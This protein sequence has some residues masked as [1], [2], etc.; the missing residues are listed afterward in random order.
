MEDQEDHTAPLPTLLRVRFSFSS[1]ARRLP[2]LPRAQAAAS[3]GTTAEDDDDDDDGKP[4]ER[5]GGDGPSR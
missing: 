5:G 2:P 4:G 3:A 1:P